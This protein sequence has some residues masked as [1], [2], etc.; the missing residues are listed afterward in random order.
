MPA[1]VLQLPET[2]EQSRAALDPASATYATKLAQFV[3]PVEDTETEVVDLLSRVLAGTGRAV[4][5]LGTTGSGKSTF[6]QSL[7]WRK[8]LGLARL[9]SIDCSD[10]SERNKLLELGTRLQTAADQARR[11][12]GLTAISIDYLESLGGI[13]N[14]EKRA[15]FQTLNGI[16]RKSPILVV[17]PVTKGE[18]A[19]SMITEAK[20]VSGTVFDSQIP[21]LNFHGPKTEAFSSIVR[22]TIAVFNEAKMLQDFLLTDAEL[23]KVRDDLVFDKEADPTIR[24]YIQRVQLHWSQKSGQ[25]KNINAK[26]PKPNEVWCVFCHPMAEDVVAMFA[27]KGSEATNA[28]IAYHA[29]LWEYVPGTQRAARWKNPT[30]L[31]YAIG[32]ALVTRILHLSP[33]SLVSVCMAYSTDSKL[34]PVR[35]AGLKEW[36]DKSKAKDYVGTSALYRQLIGSPPSRGKTKGGPAA[37][38][39]LAATMPFEVLNKIVAGSGSDRYVNHAIAACLRDKLPSNFGVVAEQLHP[40]IPGIFPDIR[41]DMPDGRQ[42]CLE[43]CYTNNQK[44]GGVAD[45]VLDKLAI[46]MDQLEQYVGVGIT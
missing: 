26:L 19:T 37:S 1:P 5:L 43:F 23:D 20:A 17:W 29:K 32:G 13:Q 45:Y 42:I 22:N 36:N 44:P 12:K 3:Q 10:L 46:Y 40:W 25:L 8:H 24:S 4:L 28:W 14:E 33:Q 18:D 11:S 2:F 38:A 34:D 27:T 21:I 6:I 7:T 9:Q 35:V 39:R 31:Q 41:I 30:R 16:L 15:F